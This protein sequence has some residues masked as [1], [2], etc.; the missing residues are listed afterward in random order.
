MGAFFNCDDVVQVEQDEQL[1]PD[2]RGKRRY[3]CASQ[4]ADFS[5]RS[6]LMLQIQPFVLA[7]T[8]SNTG[9]PAFS[10]F[11]LGSSASVDALG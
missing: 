8:Y 6:A 3:F 5:A 4:Q 11:A 10:A 9:R 1:G 2:L 7:F